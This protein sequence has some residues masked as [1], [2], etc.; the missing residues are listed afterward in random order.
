MPCEDTLL[1]CCT[2]SVTMYGVSVCNACT[3]FCP[4]P[5]HRTD[6]RWLS[7]RAPTTTSSRCVLSCL[8]ALHLSHS[9]SAHRYMHRYTHRLLV[10]PF[11]TTLAPAGDRERYRCANERARA[12]RSVRDGHERRVC[13]CVRARSR[14]R[15][16]ARF[17]SAT[18][19]R[20]RAARG[21]SDC[22]MHLRLYG[23]GEPLLNA[24]AL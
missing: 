8:P 11:H 19:T 7:L 22:V 4:R 23:T 13:R 21:T 15:R 10:P 6:T 18:G 5:R 16:L 1:S 17:R 20:T 24:F 12:R 2:N 14:A 3:R 9:T